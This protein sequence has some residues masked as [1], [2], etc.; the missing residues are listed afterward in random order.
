META[1]RV[2]V[3]NEG[4]GVHVTSNMGVFVDGRKCIGWTVYHWLDGNIVAFTDLYANPFNTDALIS[5]R[6]R[7]K[8]WRE[9][10]CMYK[11]DISSKEEGIEW[12]CECLD[13]TSP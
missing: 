4:T 10:S 7:M 8:G 12:G 11:H 5:G 13:S 9:D 2:E 6:F 3:S 1:A